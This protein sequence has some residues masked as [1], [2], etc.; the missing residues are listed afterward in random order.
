MPHHD[1]ALDDQ[2]NA[3]FGIA[4]ELFVNFRQ[5][6]ADIPAPVGYATGMHRN[7]DRLFFDVDTHLSA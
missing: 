6:L 5:A 3:L 2:H 1:G 7:P 4:D